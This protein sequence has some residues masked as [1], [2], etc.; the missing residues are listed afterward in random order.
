MRAHSK[1]GEGARTEGRQSNGAAGWRAMVTRPPAGPDRTDAFPGQGARAE[2]DGAEPAAPAAAAAGAHRDKPIT[3]LRG[4]FAARRG[5]GRRRA[6][7]LACAAVLT[8][9]LIAMGAAQRATGPASPDAGATVGAY[10]DR[11]ADEVRR[12]LDR[13]VAEGM[14]TVSVA[15]TPAIEG[16]QVRV[17]VVNAEDNRVGQRFSLEQDGRELYRSGVIRPGSTVAT[18]PAGDAKAGPATIRIQP[19]DPGTGKERGSASAI[20]VRL[21]DRSNAQGQP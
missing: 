1:P 6:A 11:S 15:P 12:E 2:R 14:M 7:V 18:C 10:R 3:A 9:G 21:V 19:V 13:Q 4:L 5:T 16:G 8:C 17:N 20:K